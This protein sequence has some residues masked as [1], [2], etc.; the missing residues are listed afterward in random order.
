MTADDGMNSRGTGIAFK[1][2]DIMNHLKLEAI[3][4]KL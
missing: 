1:L 2:I 3:N 4:L